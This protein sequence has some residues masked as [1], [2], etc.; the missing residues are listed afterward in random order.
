MKLTELGLL[1]NPAFRINFVLDRTA[2][3][4]I[5]GVV[6][7]KRRKHQVKPLA[8][9]WR[10]FSCFNS[11]NTLHVDDLGKLSFEMYF[12][13]CLNIPA[14]NFALNP[15]NG[16]VSLQLT[17]FRALIEYFRVKSSRIQECC[18]H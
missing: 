9:I 3:F 11:K 8:V 10:K 6:G 16:M 1:S 13:N 17:P 15:K 4:S 12:T 7:G 5:H 18:C 2:M 14:R